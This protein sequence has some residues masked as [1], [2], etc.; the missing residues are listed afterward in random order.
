MLVV[1]LMYEFELGIWKAIFTHLVRLLYATGPGGRLVAELDRRYICGPFE[2]QHTLGFTHL[3]SPSD[4][5]GSQHLVV[6]QSDVSPQMP[7]R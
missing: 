7:R 3:I 2:A 5:D 6:A 1:D 4:S